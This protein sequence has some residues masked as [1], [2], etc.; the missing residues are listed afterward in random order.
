MPLYEFQCDQCHTRFEARLPFSRA[1]EAVTCPKG[2]QQTRRLFSAPGIVFKGSGFYVT[3][4][5]KNGAQKD[6]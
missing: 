5:R 2:H 1:D 6:D 3:D 4:N